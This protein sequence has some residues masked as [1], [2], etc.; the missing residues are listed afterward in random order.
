MSEG[1]YTKKIKIIAFR[2]NILGILQISFR[3]Y[4][5]FCSLNMFPLFHFD[6]FH[7]VFFCRMVRWILMENE[8]IIWNFEIFFETLKLH[9]RQVNEKYMTWSDIWY[10][11]AVKNLIPADML[12]SR[13]RIWKDYIDPL[14]LSDG[15]I[16]TN[17]H[18][19]EQ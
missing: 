5:Y 17:V 19:I 18:Y 14:Y 6:I 13:H 2:Y 16:C 9:G 7:D 11:C 10:R 1:L 12:Q 8:T 4:I 3:F 15:C